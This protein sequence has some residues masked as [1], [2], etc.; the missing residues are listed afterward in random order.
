MEY[1]CIGDMPNVVFP[2]GT[3][4][5]DDELFVFYGGADKVC[6]VAKINLK[7]FIEELIK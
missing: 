7:K 3:V 4:V 5:V 1:E 6:S 2:Q